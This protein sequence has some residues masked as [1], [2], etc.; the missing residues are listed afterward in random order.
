MAMK[1]E[2]S[3]FKEGGLIPQKFTCDGQDISPALAWSDM[4]AN[5]KALVL[6]FD[7]PDAPMGTWDHWVLYNLPPETTGL[8]EAVKTLPN[9]T[10]EGLNSWSKRGYGG[11]CPPDKMHRYYFKL[12]A[13][14]APL[15]LSPGA[16]KKAVEAAMRSHILA[17]AQL[18]GK[19]DRVGR[20]Q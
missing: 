6:I 4:P 14:D 3:A 11:P 13:L 19:Y 8:A 2:S 15:E 17:E 18:M 7:D 12:Y 1:I 16:S 20:Q 10:L 9:G 5:T